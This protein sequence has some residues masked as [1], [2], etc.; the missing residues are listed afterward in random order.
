MMILMQNHHDED[1]TMNKH[2]DKSY[3]RII[4][5]QLKNDYR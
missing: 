4:M 3:E 2:H 5:I 1:H